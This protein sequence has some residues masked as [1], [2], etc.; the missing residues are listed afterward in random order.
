MSTDALTRALQP[1][2]GRSLLVGLSGGLDSTVLLHALAQARADCGGLR[3]IHVHH[4]L[5]PQAD[6]WSEHCR[7]LCA[8]L[9]VDFVLCRVEVER[10][11]GQGLEAAA[12]TA[13]HAAFAG[14]LRADEALVL[15]QGLKHVR[16]ELP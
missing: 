15:A 9:G 6:A 2:Q 13:R 11:S 4:G 7:R 10:D 16:L 12:R 14:Q 3:A 5:L 8:D 1:L